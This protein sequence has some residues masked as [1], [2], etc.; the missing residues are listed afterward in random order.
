VSSIEA[1]IITGIFVDENFS[2]H[3]APRVFFT[4]TGSNFLSSLVTEVCRLLN[5]KKVSTTAYHP[6]TNGLVERFNN[7]L[8]EAISAYVST[9][10]DD[11]DLYF[12]AILFA[13]RVSPSVSTGVAHSIYCMAVMHDYPV[14]PVCFLLYSYLHL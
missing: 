13:Y 9:N 3:G 6:Q 2:R 10:Q 5:T 4:D 12:R 8:V 11:W 7:T 14:I 1:P